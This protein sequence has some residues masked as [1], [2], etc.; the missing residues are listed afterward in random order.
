MRQ[1][2]CRV[3]QSLQTESLERLEDELVQTFENDH[4][5]ELGN[6]ELN[7]NDL[8]NCFIKQGVKLPN[9]PQ[10]WLN[11]NEFFKAAFSSTPIT[12]DSLDH[13]I[14]N[15]NSIIYQYYKD[16]YGC[17]N[18][19]SPST[20]V[21]KYRDASVKDLKKRLKKLTLEC[22]DISEIKYVSRLLRKKLCKPESLTNDLNTH[23]V[24]DHDE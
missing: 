15:L 2:S 3:I 16:S 1:R 7:Q 8:E 23:E 21:S 11:D 9:S 5:S 10:Q 12:A 14:Y 13:V 17:V 22:V 19:S 20:F 24:N 6:F 18:N 4:D